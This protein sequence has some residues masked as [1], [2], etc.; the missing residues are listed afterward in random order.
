MN[1]QNRL[2]FLYLSPNRVEI[3]EI[4]DYYYPKM[5][6]YR[7]NDHLQIYFSYIQHTFLRL[8]QF[9]HILIK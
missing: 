9:N 6:L 8:L 3:R 7:I 4:F 5:F 1:P 2:S